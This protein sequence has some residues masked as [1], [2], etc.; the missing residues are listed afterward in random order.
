M[1]AE[2]S[3]YRRDNATYI[4][5]FGY[6]TGTLSGELKVGDT[7]IWNGGGTTKVHAIT[8]V[9]KYFV[10]INEIDENEKI[11]KGRRMKKDRI[12]ARPKSEL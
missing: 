10:W 7:M 8:K 3:K 6:V 1:K 5:G 2:V 11:W 4:Q 12:V 9:S